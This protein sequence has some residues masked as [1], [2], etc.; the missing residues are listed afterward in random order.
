MTDTTQMIVML[1]GLYQDAI[2]A[3]D[4]HFEDIVI[5]A[6][7][8]LPEFLWHQFPKSREELGG[9]FTASSES[10]YFIIFKD[11]SDYTPIQAS[12]TYKPESG[13]QFAG[14][15]LQFGMFG[16]VVFEA[17]TLA[18]AVMLSRNYEKLKPRAGVEIKDFTS[19]SVM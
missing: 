15:S 12:F 14:F 16:T 4:R 6:R 9:L 13:W 5:C 2:I 19:S 8:A 3:A 17:K 7:Q 18:D 10:I 11:V 1:E